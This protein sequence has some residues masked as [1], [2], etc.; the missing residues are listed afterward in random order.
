MILGISLSD[1]LRERVYPRVIR[2][3]RVKRESNLAHHLEVRENRG[4]R[5]TEKAATDIKLDIISL[6]SITTL[7]SR[8]HI[9]IRTCSQIS[10]PV[11]GRPLHL[12]LEENTGLDLSHGQVEWVHPDGS[13]SNQSLATWLTHIKQNEEQEFQNCFFKGNVSGWIGSLGIKCYFYIHRYASQASPHS[14]VRYE[15]FL[16][17]NYISDLER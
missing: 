9:I 1:Q 7:F 17:C 15:R 10:V 11:G 5:N 12:L 16:F 3:T 4:R 2:K 13:H 6:C 14:C 8:I